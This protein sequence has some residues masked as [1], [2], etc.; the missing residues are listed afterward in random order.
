MNSRLV[1]QACL[2]FFGILPLASLAQVSA[3][4]DA[5][6][7]ANVIVTVSGVRSDGGRVTGT[8]W[9]DAPLVFCSTRVARTAAAVGQNTLEFRNVPPGRYALSVV[10][11]EDGDGR[12]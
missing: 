8:V 4:G 10:H 3:T 2:L 7:P 1:Q 5:T 9:P 6:L 12:T 11:D